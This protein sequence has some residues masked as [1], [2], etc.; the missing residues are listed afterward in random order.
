MQDPL[1]TRRTVT[2]R[3]ICYLFSIK[4]FPRTIDLNFVARLGFPAT[5]TK[6]TAKSTQERERV[7]TPRASSA[8]IILADTPKWRNWQT[9]CVQGAVGFTP[10]WVQIPP[11]APGNK[12]ARC[13]AGFFIDHTRTRHS[14]QCTRRKYKMAADAPWQLGN[15]RATATPPS[16]AKMII[17]VISVSSVVKCKIGQTTMTTSA[18]TV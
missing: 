17:S 11:S 14:F 9:R 6:P 8:T 1:G 3:M 13:T 18:A 15:K 16:T 5:G 4:G 2:F 7:L 10:V 12:K